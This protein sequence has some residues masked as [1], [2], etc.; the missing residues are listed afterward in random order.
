MDPNT[1]DT[2]DTVDTSNNDE[3]VFLDKASL[4]KLSKEQI[5]NYAVKISDV[6]SSMKDLRD[7]FHE[8]FKSLTTKIE[9]TECRLQQ[10]EGE[11]AVV[12]KANELLTKDLV[13]LRQR[14][15]ANERV[16]IRNA[17]Y[18]SNAQIVLK[19]MPKELPP[20]TNIK[21]YIADVLSLT[22]TTVKEVDL[23]KCHPLGKNGDVITSFV[24]RDKRDNV[25]MGRKFLKNKMQELN[26]LGAKKIMIL[27]HLSRDY[28]KMDF[29]CRSLKREGIIEETW[30][31][32]G[33]LFIK[34]SK[35]HAKKQ[36]CHMEDLYE[37]YGRE[38]IDN[39][40]KPLH[41]PY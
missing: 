16:I 14:V 30:F 23:D 15:I 19:N 35:D 8:T 1:S 20:H 5:A 33:R 9:E 25:L 28:A 10:T 36:I 37:Q 11:L 2:A 39:L 13:Q 31:F 21:T 22:G 38:H 26:N 32:N 24:R 3:L 17:Q 7:T 29:V 4:M 34:P 40:F 6:K 41:T 27:E 12:A 18:L